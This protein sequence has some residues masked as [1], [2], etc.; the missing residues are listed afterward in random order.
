MIL[1]L[2]KQ[3]VPLPSPPQPHVPEV[4][5]HPRA[6]PKGTDNDGGEEVAQ[7][8]AQGHAVDRPQD[9]DE[10]GDGLVWH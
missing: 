7:L 8:L 1:L 9:R 4:V 6:L 5:Q 3:P 10:E 2:S